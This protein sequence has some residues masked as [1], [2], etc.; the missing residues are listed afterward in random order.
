M[1][2]ADIAHGHVDAAD[3]LYLIAV[4]VFLVAGAIEWATT[5]GIVLSLACLGLAVTA[6][7][8]LIL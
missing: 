8:W 3:V 1:M 2:L 6:L 4:I 7:A 5:K